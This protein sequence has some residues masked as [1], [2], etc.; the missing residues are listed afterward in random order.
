[1]KKTLFLAIAF[2]FISYCW[3]EPHKSIVGKWVK[4]N[5]RTVIGTGSTDTTLVI[6]RYSETYQL[7][8]SFGS[9]GRLK[10]NDG[11]FIFQTNTTT[12]SGI[13]LYEKEGVYFFALPNFALPNKEET[14][15]LK[16][17]TIK[18]REALV[19]VPQKNKDKNAPLEMF[20]REKK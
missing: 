4:T 5:Y 9:V 8:Y 17:Q 1:M 7:S 3:G 2:V 18:E 20:Y 13:C 14:I 19:I 6:Q 15:Y 10:N 16:L 12:F 11:Q